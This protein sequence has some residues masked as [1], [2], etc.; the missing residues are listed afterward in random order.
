MVKS[1]PFCIFKLKVNWNESVAMIPLIILHQQSFDHCGVKQ[2]KCSPAGRVFLIPWKDFVSQLDIPKTVTDFY[3]DHVFHLSFI[4]DLVLGLRS[5][6]RLRIFS[7]FFLWYFSVRVEWKLYSGMFLKLQIN[8]PENTIEV[9]HDERQ[10]RSL[11]I[12]KNAVQITE[13]SVT[14]M[15]HL[16]LKSNKQN[17]EDE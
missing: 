3:M 9:Q 17:K 16:N 14:Q 10:H 1:F 4:R 13:I 2:L 11:N 8:W 5:K 7:F 12:I 6:H 15:D